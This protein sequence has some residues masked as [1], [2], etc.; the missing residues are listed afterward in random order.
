L[1]A[2]WVVTGSTSL[3]TVAAGG[4]KTVTI[5]ATVKL[6]RWMAL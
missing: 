5:V 4:S 1:H 3:G 6:R 2:V